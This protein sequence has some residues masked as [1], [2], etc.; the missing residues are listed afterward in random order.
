MSN[1]SFQPGDVVELKSEPN[2]KLTVIAVTAKSSIEY[3]NCVWFDRNAV[4]P[5]QRF[6]YVD[7]P[8]AT[9]KKS[10]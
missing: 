10:Q 5:L 7:L 9:L 8:V 1:T 2:I 4:P 3:A 6:S